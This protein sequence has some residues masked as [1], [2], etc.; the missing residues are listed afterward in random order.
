MTSKQTII[1]AGY[2]AGL[3]Q[4]GVESCPDH[5]RN[6][7]E[8]FHCWMQGYDH[9]HHVNRQRSKGAFNDFYKK[10]LEFDSN[11]LLTYQI[12]RYGVKLGTNIRKES[13]G[14]KSIP[15]TSGSIKSYIIHLM[16]AK[17]L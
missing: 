3:N 15:Y 1:D 9:G 13:L 12:R 14:P 10:G 8:C 2:I 6:H 5:I 11:E 4:K 7:Q 17:P 16:V